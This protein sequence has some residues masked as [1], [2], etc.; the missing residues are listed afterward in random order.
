VWEH[1]QIVTRIADCWILKARDLRRSAIADDERCT[2][3]VRPRDNAS[4]FRAA[5]C[6]ERTLTG[7]NAECSSGSGAQ[8]GPS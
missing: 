3:R 1:P 6:R 8:E 2:R 7:N 4:M 5:L